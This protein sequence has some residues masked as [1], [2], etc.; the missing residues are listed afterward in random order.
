MQVEKISVKRLTLTRKFEKFSGECLP[1]IDENKQ[2]SDF[3]G[4]VRN[5]MQE[6]Y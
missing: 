2:H 6:I 5:A 4:A 3:G 1:L